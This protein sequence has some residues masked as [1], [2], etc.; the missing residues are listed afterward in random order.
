[1]KNLLKKYYMLDDETKDDLEML[2][3]YQKVTQIG[4]EYPNIRIN[5]LSEMEKLMQII[6]KCIVCSGYGIDDIVTNIYETLSCRDITILDLDNL[7]IDNLLE[8]LFNDIDDEE[9]EDYEEESEYDD[10]EDE[11]EYSGKPSINNYEHIADIR[12]EDSFCICYKQ[13]K[14]YIINQINGETGNIIVFDSFEDIIRDVLRT[15]I[16]EL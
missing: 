2:Y 7:D 5:N 16:E 12:F 6:V 3:I 1:M 9:Y 4:E 15:H 11:P 13:N 10:F 8:I 14:K